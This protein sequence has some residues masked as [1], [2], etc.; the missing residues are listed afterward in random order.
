MFCEEK[1]NEAHT[2]WERI[3]RKEDRT[4]VDFTPVT[5]RT[6]QVR[7]FCEICMGVTIPQ[8]SF[9][10]VSRRTCELCVLGSQLI[11]ASDYR[12]WYVWTRQPVGVTQGKGTECLVCSHASTIQGHTGLH[13]ETEGQEVGGNAGGALTLSPISSVATP[14]RGCSSGLNIVCLFVAPLVSVFDLS[15]RSGCT[16]CTSAIR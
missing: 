2:N 6:H 7:P 4:W 3:K 10:C 15:I 5:G 1:G 14:E 16:L 12:L 8:E 13:V 11:W 9:L